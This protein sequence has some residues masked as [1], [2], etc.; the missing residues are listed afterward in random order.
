MAALTI[1]QSGLTNQSALL[2]IS[3]VPAR[4]IRCSKIAIPA[5]RALSYVILLTLRTQWIHLVVGTPTGIVCWL[6]AAIL[7]IAVPH[8]VPTAAIVAPYNL[9]LWLPCFRKHLVPHAAEGV[10]VHFLSSTKPVREPTFHPFLFTRMIFHHIMWYALT[11]AIVVPT[12]AVAGRVNVTSFY[13]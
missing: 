1:S 5:L 9:E 2:I 3:T 8:I 12:K 13:L 11:I 6:V 7:I 4:F 10:I